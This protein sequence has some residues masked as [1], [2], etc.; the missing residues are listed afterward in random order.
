MNRLFFGIFIS[1]FLLVASG[2]TRNNGDIGVLFGRWRVES[3]KADGEPVALYDDETLLYT[4]SFQ[5]SLIF[6]TVIQ[7]YTQYYDIRG[8]WSRDGDVLKLNFG[9]TGNDGQKYYDPPENLHLV[10]DGV[11]DMEI[12]KM[13]SSEMLLERVAEDGVRYVY[14]LKKAY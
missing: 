12:K 5:S 14:Y 4:W 13:T 9:Y 3:L 8:T 1:L 2:C 7:P 11:S 6:I 10:R